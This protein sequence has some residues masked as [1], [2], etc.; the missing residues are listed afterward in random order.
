MRKH[1]PEPDPFSGTSR[2][3]LPDMVPNCIPYGGTLNASG[4]GVL[5]KPINGSRLA[6]RAAL[7]ERLGRP[8]EGVA[9]HACDNPP[10]INPA[11]LLEGTR[12]DNS[13]DMVQRGRTHG[14]RRD[15]THCKSGHDLTPENVYTG[16]RPGKYGDIPIRQCFKCRRR[17]QVA[18]AARRKAARH[19]AKALKN[20][21]GETK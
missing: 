8:V 4:Y 20:L 2:E 19:A 21:E 7:A 1:R 5:P 16:T 13:L 15:Q 10:C 6:H 14:G 3:G 17:Y 9:R 12:A 18:A 11:H